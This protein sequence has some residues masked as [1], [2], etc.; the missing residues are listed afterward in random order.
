MSRQDKSHNNSKIFMIINLLVGLGLL[1]V[2]FSTNRL[3]GRL[4]PTLFKTPTPISVTQ[5]VSSLEKQFKQIDEQLAQSLSASFSYNVPSSIKLDDTAAIE[6]LI[7]PSVAPQDLAKE[8]TEVG[9]VVTGTIEIVPLMKAELIAR[10]DGL[11]V[12]SLEETPI[13]LVSSDMTTKW[14][15]FVKA[16]KPGT[17]QLTIAIYRLVKYDG[18]DYWSKVETYKADID[19]EVTLAQR[20]VALDWKWVVGTLIA[21]VGVFISYRQWIEGKKKKGKK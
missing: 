11:S 19:V 1:T 21:I 20:V 6:L 13:Q 14:T 3:Y 15:W 10:D 2:I 8:I 17:H 4:L 12:E 7:N 5:V 18:K 9:Q 16:Q